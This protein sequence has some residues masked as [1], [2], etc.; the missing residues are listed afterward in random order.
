[1]RIDIHTHISPDRIAP[2]VL[3]G[4]TA[5]F[6]YPAVGVNTI[7]GI[8]AHM[9][10]SGVD[11]S[12]V[13]GVVERVDHVKPANDW[14]IT[15]QDDMLV[16]FGA[17]HPDFEDMPGEIRRLREAGIKGVKLHPMVNQFFPDD[18]KMF[19]IYEEIGED[20]VVEIH[21][22]RWAHTTPDDTVYSP[23]G[24]VMNMIR[25]FPKM[26]VVCLHLG[27]FYMLDEAERELIGKDN[28][29]IDTTWPPEL[30]EVGSGTLA[31]IINKHGADKVCFGTDFPLADMAKDS[32][33]IEN[34]PI[35]D[36][37]KE[38]ILGENFRELVGL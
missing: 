37:G 5:Q 8:K 1:M 10:A 6:G 24:R 26:K 28:V 32:Q 22:G 17:I 13:L 7:D 12:V 19:P 35:P 23:P 29:I 4:M 33:F 34:L 18:P 14:L 25:Q 20:M 9:R 11:K 31:A 16:P 3:E 36:S 2:P 15:I 27:G 38:R 30:K 21:S